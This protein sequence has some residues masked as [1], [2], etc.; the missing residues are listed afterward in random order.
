MEERT[1]RRGGFPFYKNFE[2]NWIDVPLSCIL[3]VLLRSIVGLGISRRRI[4]ESWKADQPWRKRPHSCIGDT[5]TTWDTP[6]REPPNMLKFGEWVPCA[7]NDEWRQKI[8]SKIWSISRPRSPVRHRRGLSQV[9]L[10]LSQAP[11]QRK[12]STRK[13]NHVFIY[14]LATLPVYPCLWRTKWKATELAAGK[15][16]T[17]IQLLHPCLHADVFRGW[18]SEPGTKR[19]EGLK[20]R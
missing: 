14:L 16:S 11:H 1:W 10:W 2:W 18:R 6:K 4:S 9:V 12:W 3:F 5:G 13:I 20:E 15:H 19:R 17:Q 8:H 7:M